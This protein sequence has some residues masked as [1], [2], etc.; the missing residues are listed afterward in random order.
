M[1]FHVLRTEADILA[2]MCNF[3]RVFITKCQRWALV[4]VVSCMKIEE[5]QFI[6]QMSGA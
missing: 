1:N 6:M 5:P 3:L 2:R 4:F